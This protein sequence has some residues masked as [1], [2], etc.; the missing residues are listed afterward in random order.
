MARSSVV[1]IVD[2]PTTTPVARGIG[3][4]KNTIRIMTHITTVATMSRSSQ[5]CHTP[6]G[7]RVVDAVKS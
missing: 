3:I 1:R 4:V 6:T 5:K 2:F 7:E